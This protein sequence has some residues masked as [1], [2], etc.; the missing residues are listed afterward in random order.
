MDPDFKRK[1]GFLYGNVKSDTMWQRA[2]RLIFILR[3][4]I[5]I[6]VSVVF[7]EIPV[8][9]LFIIISMNYFLIFY[10]AFKKP[11]KTFRENK[12]DLYN[13]GLVQ[14]ITIHFFMFSDAMPD[15]VAQYTV[16]WSIAIFLSWILY[17][18]TWP[19]IYTDIIRRTFLVFVKKYNLW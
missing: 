2:W 8:W 11:F 3:R 5:I 10:S 7:K 9:Q 6:F 1:Y 4:F 18:N 17:I 12:M 13:E 19:I 15:P 14:A 16:G